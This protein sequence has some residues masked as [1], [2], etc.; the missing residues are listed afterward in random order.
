MRAST[1]VHAK[2]PFII[3][4]TLLC[5]STCHDEIAYVNQLIYVTTNVGSTLMVYAFL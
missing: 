1:V 2:F 4:S 3:G 5:S